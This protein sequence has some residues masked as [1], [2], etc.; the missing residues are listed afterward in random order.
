MKAVVWGKGRD[1]WELGFRFQISS[2]RFQIA[3][4][5]RGGSFAGW[6]F[7]STLWLN[8]LV[9]FDDLICVGG[10]SGQGFNFF[11]L[12]LPQEGVS[13]FFDWG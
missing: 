5:N 3:W 1:Y 8:A 6:V 12:G 10:R 13:I 11:S 2:F 4:F 9:R 7:V